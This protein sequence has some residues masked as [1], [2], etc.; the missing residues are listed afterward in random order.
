MFLIITTQ[1]K[2]TRTNN[3]LHYTYK[4]TVRANK[5]VSYIVRNRFMY[6]TSTYLRKRTQRVTLSVYF[7]KQQCYSM[8]VLLP[9]KLSM[10]IVLRLHP[11]WYCRLRGACWVHLPEV[12]V[13]KPFLRT[14]TNLKQSFGQ[15]TYNHKLHVYKKPI[16]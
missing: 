16:S 8:H 5:P 3:E 9:G 10:C 6:I 4:K 11:R 13:V 12:I 1:Q 14:H 2:T 7:S 15:K